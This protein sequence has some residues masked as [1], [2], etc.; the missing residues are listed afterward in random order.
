MNNLD[1]PSS[2]FCL[3]SLTSPLD[4]L[5]IRTSL[6]SSKLRPSISTPQKKQKDNKHSTNI[7]HRIALVHVV[8]RLVSMGMI[9]V[10]ASLV[11]SR[12]DLKLEN[13]IGNR[14]LCA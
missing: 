2:T 6:D 3:T 4:V 5:S 11:W 7:A 8:I 9:V 13:R 10:G 12:Q 1:V 14:I